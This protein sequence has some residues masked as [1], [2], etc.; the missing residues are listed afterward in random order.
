V[1]ASLSREAAIA[2]AVSVAAHVPWLLL[3]SAPAARARVAAPIEFEIVEAPAPVAPPE[4]PP[5][6]SPAAPPTAMAPAAPPP[7]R[8][9]PRAP[10]AVAPAPAAEP[11]RAGATLIAAPGAV[12]DFTLVQGDAGAFVGGTTAS[13]GTSTIA[14]RGA[15]G[16]QGAPEPARPAPPAPSPPRPAPAPPAVRPAAP[17]AGSFACSH[18]FPVAADVDD[19]AVRLVVRVRSDGS[20]ESVVVLSDPGSGFGEAARRCALAQRFRPAE[21]PDGAPT[22]GPTAPF[23]VRFRR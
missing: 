3:D 23:V 12:A 15:A 9:P 1:I 2:I 22:A 18:L 14:V 7:T 16:P 21:G 6:E 20:A 13:Y 11:A 5:P 4:A 19:A 10:R 8:V 17:M